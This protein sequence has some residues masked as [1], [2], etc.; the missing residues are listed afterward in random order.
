[1]GTSYIP[2]PPWALFFCLVPL[3]IFWLKTKSLKQILITG[4][5]Y[6]FT[7]TLVGFNWIAHTVHEFG[8]LP[9]P[10]SFLVLIIFC[11]FASLHYPLTGWIWHKLRNKLNWN[12]TQQL[13][14]LC[15]LQSFADRIFPM[16]FDWHMG[17]AWFQNFWSTHQT[18]EIFG[19][20]GLAN[21][22]VFINGFFTWAWFYR[23]NIRASM[24]AATIPLLILTAL[25]LWGR[26]LVQ[27]WPATNTVAISIIQANI[28]NLEKQYAEKGSNFRESII[29]RY[30]DLSKKSLA[31]NP[32]WIVW[33]E[34]AFPEVLDKQ[35][36]NFGFGRPLKSF[37]QENN[38]SL[39]TG[40]YGTDALTGQ[41][42]NSFYS[43]GS[44][45]EWMNPPYGKTVLLAFGEYFPFSDWFPKLRDWFP[46]VGDF[47]RG[48]GPSIQVVNDI[49][50]GA[51]ICYEGLFD[52]FSRNLAS[53][54]AEILVNASND[55][56]YGTW[57]Q[58]YQHLLMTL[59]RS[60]ETRRPLIRSTNTGISTVVTAQGEILNQSPMEQEWH[61]YYLVPYEKNPS[62]SF[63]VRMG[64]WL[65][66][67]LLLTLGLFL[68]VQGLYGSTRLEN[69]LRPI[70][71]NGD[72]RESPR[73]PS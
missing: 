54:G 66:P 46:E 72:F 58:P 47:A 23:K 57:Q 43:I 30:I 50:I 17:Y 65:F 42:T 33:P 35:S 62:Q 13:L 60:L 61:G 3:W 32:Q 44:N 9:K 1:M 27:K 45:G 20:V 68:V 11:A 37:L 10:V 4:W 19:M 67:M 53:Q 71:R 64:Y 2:F 12:I 36:L 48:K 16:V 21:F 40:A 8:H 6:Q 38:V 5:L 25:N 29:E 59:S 31:Q 73:R 56:W 49:K 55:S 41:M 34:T 63:F 15:I 52:W 28:G 22:T 24:F 26:Q 18:A 7:L 69:P 51:Q 14:A 70:S 39:L